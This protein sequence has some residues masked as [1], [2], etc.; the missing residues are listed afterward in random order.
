MRI[1]CILV[2]DEP[3]SRKNLGMMLN[4]YCPLV[5]IVGEAGSPA[6]AIKLIT[7]HQPDLVFLDIEMGK[8]SGFDLLRSLG[9]A[10]TFEV[11][12]VTAYDK[13]G[14]QAVKACA[15][16]YL[17]K[18]INIL[19]LTGAVNKARQHIGPKRENKRLTELLANIGR[20]EDEQKIAL[21]LTD[22]I[23]FVAVNTIIRLEAERNYTHIYLE[24]GKKYLICKT[25]KDYD[26]LLM[27]YGFLRTHQSHLVNF[28][29]ISAY[30]KT[31]GG[32]ISMNDGSSIPVSRTKKD[33]IM[34]RLLI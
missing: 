1:K 25:L 29:K 32:Y 34:K 7:Q 6:E 17:L 23:E 24:G 30:V 5:E 13:Y 21:P 22:K 31:D 12:F 18:P 10:K 20:G 28:K 16:D 11:I 33:E 4:E 19:E 26:E 15:I 27:P 2:D 14:I 3:K 9:D 8:E